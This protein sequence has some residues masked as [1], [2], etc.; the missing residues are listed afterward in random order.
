[1]EKVALYCFKEIAHDGDL[2]SSF[3]RLIAFLNN[4]YTINPPASDHD[5]LA[6]APVFDTLRKMPRI[7]VGLA[8]E[9]DIEVAINPEDTKAEEK[10][11]ARRTSEIQPL[12]L[13][14]PGGP[15]S[16]SR[17]RIGRWNAV[18]LEPLIENARTQEVSMLLTLYGDR[19]RIAVDPELAALTLTGQNSRHM[20]QSN[21]RMW[22]VLQFIARARVEGLTSDALAKLTNFDHKVVYAKIRQGIA[23]N[24]IFKVNKSGAKRGD[25]TIHKD[26]RNQVPDTWI[27]RNPEDDDLPGPSGSARNSVGAEEEDEIKPVIMDTSNPSAPKTVRAVVDHIFS[28]LTKNHP[29]TITYVQLFSSVFPTATEAEWSLFCQTAEQMAKD[30]KILKQLQQVDGGNQRL[31][32]SLPNGQPAD[33]IALATQPP[34]SCPVLKP[35][36][37]PAATTGAPKAFV[38]RESTY[39]RKRPA[40]HPPLGETVS[41]RLRPLNVPPGHIVPLGVLTNGVAQPKPKERQS[42]PP[43][44]IERKNGTRLPSP[45][46]VP[47]RP[48]TPPWQKISPALPR[49]PVPPRK[50]LIDPAALR[51][52][53]ASQRL[54]TA[55]KMI[56]ELEEQ[57]LGIKS[58]NGTL[59]P[60]DLRS[61]LP[62]RAFTTSVL[63]FLTCMMLET[64]SLLPKVMIGTTELWKAI[65]VAKPKNTPTAWSK[66]LEF[67]K[68]KNIFEMHRF[69]LPIYLSLQIEKSDE[70]RWICGCVDFSSK[71]LAIYDCLADPG[72]SMSS[73]Q[74]MYTIRHLSAWLNQEAVSRETPPPDWKVWRVDSTAKGT[75]AGG[76]AVDSAFFTWLFARELVTK[77][78]SE[79]NFTDQRVERERCWLVIDGCQT[80]ERVP[81]P[82]DWQSAPDPKQKNATLEEK[83]V[84]TTP[85]GSEKPSPGPR[86][87]SGTPQSQPQPA[88]T[89]VPEEK[90]TRSTPPPALEE[91]PAEVLQVENP[92]RERSAS[93][94]SAAG[95][96]PSAP[97]QS[98]E[99]SPALPT[100]TNGETLGS[101][102]SPQAAPVSTPAPTDEDMQTD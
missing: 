39:P 87:T 98:L 8:P 52:M 2:G 82:D 42:T 14:G 64:A 61:M 81:L 96:R 102:M 74:Y 37:A 50:K 53:T 30:Q 31:F 25:H 18:T 73:P 40:D 7:V 86:A 68:L 47:K 11:R 46:W 44:A 58:S 13:G 22:T 83:S 57:R 94:S 85:Q 80:L 56:D 34:K 90:P 27:V 3:P 9:A 51:G 67:Y 59:T 33:P 6:P 62:G 48:P 63:N 69:V 70:P 29:K 19:L 23:M 54:E 21:S 15:T 77:Q 26:Y 55:T 101:E 28:V 71:T 60:D 20:P 88:P 100:T 79:M 92:S 10:R 66:A 78:S 1:M 38:F 93:V 17:S 99:P 43:W 49:K 65:E 89:P 32:V 75:I 35:T 91:K 5:R 36:A 4:Y 97:S 45:D 41:K 12:P 95:A 72:S 24:L 16:P 76:K 84:S